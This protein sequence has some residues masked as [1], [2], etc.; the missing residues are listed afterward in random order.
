[1][2]SRKEKRNFGIILMLILL[3]CSYLFYRSLI[4]ILA[5]PLLYE[6]GKAV[7]AAYLI[8][9]RNNQILSEFRDF[10]YSLSTSF[11]TG[12]HMGEGMKEAEQY[13]T[14]IH[15]SQS[16]LANELAFML[17]AVEETGETDLE[18]LQRFAER[19]ALEDIYTFVDVFRSC[20]ETGG[21][22]VSAV[23]KTANLLSEKI[24]LEKEIKTMVSQKKFEGRII[25]I[26]PVLV[27]L[28][29]Q[30]MSPS[31][32]EVM[33]AT[34]AGRMMMTL[35]LSLNVLTILWIE[36]MTNIEI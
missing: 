35:A 14:E 30:C 11:S 20:R 1:M 13:L 6:K 21:D 10:L 23:S 19:T 17:K 12:R 28:F 4:L 36:R 27:I 15:G 32:L 16:I 7:Y 24:R 9:K 2:L 18:V 26:M 25:G 5:F 34:T 33:Y 3:L 22:M 8:E 31:Y 29:L